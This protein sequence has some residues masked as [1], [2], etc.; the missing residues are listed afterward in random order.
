MVVWF[1]SSFSVGIDVQIGRVASLA[2]ICASMV[3]CTDAIA[4]RQADIR[5][6]KH[7]FSASS[8]SA[9][10]ATGSIGQAGAPGAPRPVAV[11]GDEVCV[12]CHAPH[13]A[14]ALDSAGNPLGA[15][16]WNRR[17]KDNSYTGYSS[18]S[19]DAAAQ[20]GDPYSGQPNASSK[21]C[22]SCHDGTVAIG[23]VGVTAGTMES[24]SGA[25]VDDV[26]VQIPF[27]GTLGASSGG[28]GGTIPEGVF[29]SDTGFTRRLG[30]DLRNDHPISVSFTKTL[31]DAD[32]ELRVPA[33]DTTQQIGGNALVAPGNGYVRQSFSAAVGRRS[34]TVSPL[35]PLTP[36]TSSSNAQVACS[37]CHDP[38]LTDS[39]SSASGKFL[40]A[41]RFQSQAPNKV[42]T[43]APFDAGR[44]VICLACHSKGYTVWGNSAHANDTVAQ[45]QYKDAAAAVRDF[46]TGIAVW[47]ASCLNCHDPHTNPNAKRLLREATDQGY[48]SFNVSGGVALVK[49]GAVAKGAALEETCF[50]CHRP[51]TDQAQVLTLATQTVPDIWTDFNGG[52]SYRMPITSVAQYAQQETHSIG[53]ILGQTA[54]PLAGKDF[55]ETA[56]NLGSSLSDFSP[57]TSLRH[58]ECTDCHNP[59]RVARGNHADALNNPDGDVRGTARG[60]WISNALKGG[61]GVEPIY[62]S[63][64]TSF[65]KLPVSYSLRCGSGLGTR[66]SGCSDDV[67]FEYQ[68]CLKC[69]SNYAYKDFDGIGSGQYNFAGRPTIGSSGLTPAGDTRFRGQTTVNVWPAGAKYTNQAVEFFAPGNHRGELNASGQEPVVL[70][71]RSW[72]PVMAPTGRT[73]AERNSASNF[74]TPWQAGMGTQTMYCADCHGNAIT[75]TTTNDPNFEVGTTGPRRPWG[76]HGSTNPFILK[77][78]YNVN[79]IDLCTRCHDATSGRSGFSGSKS[80]NLHAFH[81]GKSAWDERDV[82][83]RCNYCHIAVPHGWK[84]KALLADTRTVGVEVGFASEAVANGSFSNGSSYTKGPYYMNSKLRVTTWKRAGNW[85]AADCNGD[86]NGMKASCFAK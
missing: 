5:N 58:A 22:L 30:T 85:E 86:I 17:V 40:R 81:L 77:G 80:T 54:A 82:R 11:G 71:H 13:G 72:H 41:N 34:A 79:E 42:D 37:T 66:Y 20:A 55:V 43:S 3:A 29:G 39:V 59:H 23:N 4:A 27:Q 78:Q 26:G 1:C 46:P 33:N 38:H 63:S 76:P 52:G 10:R 49:K 12:F 19:L 7:N 14:A 60:N 32:G 31:A 67:K 18:T 84:H 9:V 36:S 57:A 16:L 61:Y 73:S 6:T 56:E 48:A 47:Q 45:P 35:L 64:N 75:S 15:P 28:Y 68:I 44:D 83:I 62:D 25:S 8:T 21:L 51:R 65:G 2:I 50:M 74:R 69:H 70:D 53:N 24:V